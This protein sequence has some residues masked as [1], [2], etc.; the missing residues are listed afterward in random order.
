MERVVFADSWQ[1][2]FHECGLRSFDDFFSS[3]PGR[4]DKSKKRHVGV[5]NLGNGANRKVFFL[6]RFYHPHFKDMFFAFRNFGHLCSQAAC[7]WKNA[8]LLLDKGIGTY[9]PVCYG[10]QTKC[11]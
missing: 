2:F 7:E 8:N 1:R 5:L 9:R 4:T 3:S 11:G 6:K 10:E